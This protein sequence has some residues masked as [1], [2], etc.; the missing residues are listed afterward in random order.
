MKLPRVWINTKA[1]HDRWIV[2]QEGIN[3]IPE[4]GFEKYLHSAEVEELLAKEREKGIN[5]VFNLLVEKHG[6]NWSSPVGLTIAAMA[7]AA[8]KDP[9]DK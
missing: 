3:F 4:A 9:D 1:A 8:R 5:D 2:L 6:L 7:K